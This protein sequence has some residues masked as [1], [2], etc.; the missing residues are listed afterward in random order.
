MLY[1][2][3]LTYVRPLEEVD[4]HLDTHRAWLA[5]HT[6]GGRILVAG[7]LEG[8]TGGVLIANCDSR[9]VL[10]RMLA[11]DSFRVHG[12]VDCEVRGF[13]AAMRAQAWPAQWAPEAKAVQH[14]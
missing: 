9:E 4:V 13:T 12:L 1:V 3:T 6:R 10:D 7:P 14:Q 8:R 11:A 2:I 5:E